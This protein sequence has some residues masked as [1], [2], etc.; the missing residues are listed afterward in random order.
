[1]FLAQIFWAFFLGKLILKR[2]DIHSKNSDFYNKNPTNKISFFSS[3]SKAV[4]SSS[5]TI[6]SICAFVIFFSVICEIAASVCL[7]KK[8]SGGYSILN[9]LCE[10]CKGSIYCIKFENTL[11][12]AFFSGLCVGFGGF[13]VHF[14]TFA[15]CEGFYVD[16][17]RFIAF[18][19]I[20]GVVCGLSALL[21]AY[22]RKSE[23][24]RS[25]FLS[26]DNLKLSSFFITI[27]CLF[28]GAY[29]I[30]LIYKKIFQK[31]Y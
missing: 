30:Y 26:F 12:C 2:V 13:C 16:K 7:L 18:K 9:I 28:V 22:I 15:V 31:L 8:D 21:Y 19:T 14:Q 17:V 27:F 1:L 24:V 11:L 29:L 25:V 5:T 20:H 6:I 3:I 4:I 23:P 10:F